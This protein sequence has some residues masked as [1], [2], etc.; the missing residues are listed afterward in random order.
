MNRELN[1]QLTSRENG[2]IKTDSNL[3]ESSEFN[4]ALHVL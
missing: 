3:P 1:T 4:E 2:G